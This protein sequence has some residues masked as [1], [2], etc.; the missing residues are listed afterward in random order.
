MEHLLPH[1]YPEIRTL[2]RLIDNWAVTGQA[3]ALFY[4]NFMFKCMQ[5]TY[6]NLR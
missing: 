4:Q 6:S 2:P 3:K 1:I 5:E